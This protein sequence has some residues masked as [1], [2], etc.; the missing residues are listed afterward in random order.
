MMVHGTPCVGTRM[1]P[2]RGIPHDSA[3]SPLFDM[4]VGGSGNCCWGYVV[5]VWVRITASARELI[6]GLL[7][8]DP[9]KRWVRSSRGVWQ[10]HDSRG[11]RCPR[12]PRDSSS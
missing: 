3:R 8:K 9:L 10:Q 11:S 5:Q 7:E 2:R 4:C 12:V 6:C 1:V